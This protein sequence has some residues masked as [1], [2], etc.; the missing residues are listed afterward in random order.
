MS[1]LLLQKRSILVCVDRT[2]RAELVIHDNCES[3]NL[4]KVGGI[5]YQLVKGVVSKEL[6]SWSYIGMLYPRLPSRLLA[7]PVECRGGV[8]T[9]QCMKH[10]Q[11]HRS[12]FT[13]EVTYG[14]DAD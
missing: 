4:L 7:L 10:W 8:T 3:L 5:Y 6:E 1:L 12:C 13:K 11:G 2:G 14:I 9:Y